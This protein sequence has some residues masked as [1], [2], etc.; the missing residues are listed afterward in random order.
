MPYIENQAGWS[1]HLKINR[2]TIIFKRR[3][4]MK[5]TV[6]LFTIGLLLIAG[7]AQATMVSQLKGGDLYQVFNDLFYDAG[8]ISRM[9]SN[10]ELLQSEFFL[11]DGEDLFFGTPGDTLHIDLTFRESGFGGDLGIWNGNQDTDAGNYQTLISGKDIHKGKFTVQDTTFTM[12]DGFMF[13]DTRMDGGEAQQRWSADRDLNPLGKKDHFLAF[14]IEDD[15][16]LD[17][18]NQQFGT[19]YTTDLDDLWLIAFEELNLGDADYNDLVAVV[20]RPALLN[21][22]NPPV[23]T[24]LPGAAILLVSGLIGTVGLRMKRK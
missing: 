4:V 23:P 13:S 24:P 10:I 2:S 8:D 9:G 11:P 5:K 14:A 12:F 19:N 7:H 16:L 22:D 6:L 3:S 18:Y 17:F 15:S 21:A 1:R 20:S